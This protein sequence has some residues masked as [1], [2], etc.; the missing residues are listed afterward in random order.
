LTSHETVLV[1]ILNYQS[2]YKFAND[3]LYILVFWTSKYY[4]QCMWYTCIF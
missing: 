4:Y 3:T 2:S 1:C